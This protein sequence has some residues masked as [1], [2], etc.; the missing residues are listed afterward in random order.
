MAERQTSE[1]LGSPEGER[2]DEQ[3]TASPVEVVEFNEAGLVLKVI[4]S[5][6]LY[7]IAVDFESP[8]GETINVTEIDELPDEIPNDVQ[9]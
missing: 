7:G 3:E 5:G 1:P 2:S 6:R 8:M 4:E 9:T